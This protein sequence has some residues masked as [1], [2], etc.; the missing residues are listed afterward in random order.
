MKLILTP[1]WIAESCFLKEA[2]LWGGFYRYPKS[3]IVPDRV[4]F[5]FDSDRQG[6]YEPMI[7][8]DYGYVES[9]EAVRVGLPP[10]PE[11][12]A[13]FDDEQTYMLSDPGTIQQFLKMD[14]DEAEKKKLRKELARS[15][16]TGHIAGR[17]GSSV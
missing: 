8:D 15:K 2:L 13:M 5:R 16:K 6:E 17:L 10:N 3:E 14:I 7:I 9:E 1:Y 11:W 4:D 12:E